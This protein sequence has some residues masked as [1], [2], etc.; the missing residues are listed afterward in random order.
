MHL[1]SAASLDFD[2]DKHL[3]AIIPRNR[4]DRLPRP[5]SHFLGYRETPRKPIGN[6]IVAA[7]SLLGGFI[8]ILAVA[9]LFKASFVEARGGPVI[10]GSF[11]RVLSRSGTISFCRLS[12]PSR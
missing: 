7:W 11:V 8:G 1:P 2:I 4:L 12:R 5:I 3:S 10:V 9:G 6:I